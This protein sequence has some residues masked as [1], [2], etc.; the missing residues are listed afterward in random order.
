MPFDGAREQHVV[1]VGSAHCRAAR[2]HVLVRLSTRRIRLLRPAIGQLVGDSRGRR[3][4][5]VLEFEV[6]R[7]DQGERAARD[8]ELRSIAERRLLRLSQGNVDERED[9]PHL[10]THTRR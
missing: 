10:P 7:A 9:E 5:S 6:Q 8:V 1:P 4:L 3:E 2:R